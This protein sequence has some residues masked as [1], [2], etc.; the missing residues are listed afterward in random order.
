MTSPRWFNAVFVRL[1][2]TYPQR[3]LVPL[4]E[5]YSTHHRSVNTVAWIAINAIVTMEIH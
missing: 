3:S 1:I 2:A 4:S 5:E